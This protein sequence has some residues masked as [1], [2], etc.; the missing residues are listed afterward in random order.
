LTFDQLSCV[1]AI[2]HGVAQLP[3]MIPDTPGTQICV[4]TG[5][6]HRVCQGH[7]KAGLEG[8]VRPTIAKLVQPTALVANPLT[9]NRST[10]P[11]TPVWQLG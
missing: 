11:F 6:S 7:G 2:G 9:V 5:A 4:N 8:I 3:L 10:F 1:T